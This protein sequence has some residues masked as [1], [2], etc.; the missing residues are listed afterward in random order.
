[1]FKTEVTNVINKLLKIYL[2]RGTDKLDSNE[3]NAT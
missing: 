3:G 1:M 2:E